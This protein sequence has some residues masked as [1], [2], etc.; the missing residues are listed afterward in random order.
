[1]KRILLATALLLTV[2]AVSGQSQMQ[3]APSSSA[4]AADSTNS[5]T[6]PGMSTWMMDRAKMNN[7][8]ISR[9]AY[10]DEM[11]RRW[12]AMDRDKR[13]LSVDQLNGMY[14]GGAGSPGMVERQTNATN[15]TGTEAKGQNSG[16]K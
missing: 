1:M 14:G 4:G 9:Q 15:P 6:T 3:T 10:M 5:K 8:Y 13:G 12:D 2:G 16:G 11:G 7:G